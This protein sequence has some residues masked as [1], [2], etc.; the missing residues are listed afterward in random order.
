MIAVEITMKDATGAKTTKIFDGLP[1]TVVDSG[2]KSVVNTYKALTNSV[3]TTANKI[4]TTS[5]E[6][7]A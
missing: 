7:G 6:L 3:E 5:L 1:D 2:L 4:T